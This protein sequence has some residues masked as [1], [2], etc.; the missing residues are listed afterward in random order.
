[1]C[2]LVW[3][4][5]NDILL[6]GNRFNQILLMGLV[7]LLRIFLPTNAV[8]Q[9]YLLFPGISWS[10]TGRRYDLIERNFEDIAHFPSAIRTRKAIAVQTNSDDDKYG[11]SILI[12]VYFSSL[13]YVLELLLLQ[14]YAQSWISKTTLTLFGVRFLLCNGSSRVKQDRLLFD[15]LRK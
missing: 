11:A 12:C 13:W 7:F 10:L 15:F 14:L 8:T 1:M 4:C 2:Q 5:I 3:E 6:Y 9:F